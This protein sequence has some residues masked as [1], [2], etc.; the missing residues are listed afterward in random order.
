MEKLKEMA[1]LRLELEAAK[2]EAQKLRLELAV[3]SFNLQRVGELVQGFGCA[4]VT[5]LCKKKVNKLKEDI[6]NIVNAY[7][8]G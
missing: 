5:L 2:A 8:T 6:K 1:A 7:Y 4:L 3:A